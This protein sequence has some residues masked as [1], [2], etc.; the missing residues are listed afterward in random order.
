MTHPLVAT[1]LVGF[2]L[3]LI[4]RLAQRALRNLPPGPK[5]LPLIG[6]VPH[7]ADQGG[8]SSPQRRDD[9]GDTLDFQYLPKFAHPPIPLSGELMYI[10]AFGRGILVINSQR[11]AIDLLE[12]RSSIY[13]D[14]PRYISF[15]EF[16]TENLTFVFTRY[17]DLCVIRHSVLFPC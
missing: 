7:A 10:S 14:R 8:L 6:D 12:K 11:V 5:G 1:P 16:L 4:A 17:G 3:W 13:S 2:V 9:Y 15:S